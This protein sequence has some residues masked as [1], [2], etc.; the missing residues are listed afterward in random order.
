MM[1]AIYSL[2]TS[3]N[4]IGVSRKFVYTMVG[5]ALFALG[6]ITDS[7]YHGTA[8]LPAIR[9]T[10]AAAPAAA[11]AAAK[12][13]KCQQRRADIAEGALVDE[14]EN[15]AYAAGTINLPYCPSAPAVIK[16]GPTVIHVR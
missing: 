14:R 12:V 16:A 13:A 3:I 6:A 10:A 7:M 11:V 8:Y 15:G 1:N 5:A 4:W 2:D 9:A